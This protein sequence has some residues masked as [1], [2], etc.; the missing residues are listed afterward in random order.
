MGDRLLLALRQSVAAFEEIGLEYALIGGFAAAVRGR[1]RFT[2][3]LD[4]LGIADPEQCANV[5]RALR[6]RGFAHMD[7]ADRR[8]L[9]EVEL[10]RFWLPVEDNSVS[11]GVDL[12]IAR[13]SYLESFVHAARLESYHGID[14]RVATREDLILL[15]MA[16]WRPIDRADAIE[17]ASLD[18][19]SLNWSYLRTQSELQQRLDRLEEVCQAT[20]MP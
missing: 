10:L 9:D 11:I 3:D 8:R 15:K 17:L 13:E 19:E 18:P 4:V 16:S 12:Q 20:G 1:L 14:L 2:Q 6:V 7:R 5:V